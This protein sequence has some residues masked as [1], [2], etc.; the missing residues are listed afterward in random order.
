[1][2][3]YVARLKDNVSL[4]DLLDTWIKWGC[5]QNSLYEY[6]VPVPQDT[7]Q[8]RNDKKI[9]STRHTSPLASFEPLLLYACFAPEWQR[10]RWFY[11]NDN[12]EGISLRLY[13]KPHFDAFAFGGPGFDDRYYIQHEKGEMQFRYVIVRGYSFGRRPNT[14]QSNL[15]LAVNR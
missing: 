8:W 2:P 15:A 5:W 4:L 11:Y 14:Q 3:S 13:D 9:T 6:G 12:A 10:I 7:H 1:M